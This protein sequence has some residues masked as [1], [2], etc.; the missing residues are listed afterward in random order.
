MQGYTPTKDQVIAEFLKRQN[1]VNEQI[2][3]ERE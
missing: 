3:A 1:E 2:E